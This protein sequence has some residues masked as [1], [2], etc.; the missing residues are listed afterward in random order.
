MLNPVLKGVLVAA[1][2]AAS[3][4]AVAQGL[5]SSVAQAR[6]PLSASDAAVSTGEVRKVDRESGTLTLRHGPLRNL[7]MPGM[8]MVF[9]VADRAWLT[10]LKE[11]DRV[12]FVAD[13]VRGQ[14]TVVRLD[15]QSR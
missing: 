15:L 7:G 5:E 14:L 10:T 3:L 6:T 9:R 4:A 2:A 1:V 8:T 13:S 12:R 11:G